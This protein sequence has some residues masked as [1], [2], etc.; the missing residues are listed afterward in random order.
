MLLQGG[1][2]FPLL[3]FQSYFIEANTVSYSAASYPSQ[4]K[5]RLRIDKPKK[6]E[7]TKRRT[8][9]VLLKTSTKAAV[10]CDQNNFFLI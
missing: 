7:Q 5:N 1:S 3:Q 10:E 2:T 8:I 9:A 4:L 6:I